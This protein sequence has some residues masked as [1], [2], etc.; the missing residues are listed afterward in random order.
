[1]S[2]EVNPSGRLVDI[3]VYDLNETPTEN[4]YGEF[5]Y[6]N[7]DEITGGTGI[8]KFVN[9][10]EGIYV[11]YKFYETAA[12]EGLIDSDGPANLKS[13]FNSN[14]GTPFRGCGNTGDPCR[15][16]GIYHEEV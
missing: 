2:G 16:I 13:N 9:Y 1:M 6:T 8:A 4:N 15:G 12:A 5:E 10:V 11:G 7:S 3:N 14:T